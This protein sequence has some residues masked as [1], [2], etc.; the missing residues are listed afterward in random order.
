MTFKNEAQLKKFLMSKCVK[1]VENTERKVHEEFAGNLN[2]FYT[3]FHP[4]EYIRTGALF[5]SL[6][7]T[8]VKLNGNRASAEVY[9]NEPSYQKGVMQLQST[10]E[11]GRLG[12]A[13]WDDGKIFDYAVHRGS[14]GGYVYGT[15]IW[16]DSINSLGDLRSLLLFE[17]KKQL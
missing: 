2:Q 3:E 1:A 15:S 17:V 14:H 10:P 6:E 8:G 13:E 12:Y 5:D 4:E 9:F 11:T 7:K 16:N